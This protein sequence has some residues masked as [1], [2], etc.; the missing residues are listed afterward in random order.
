[1]ENNKLHVELPKISTSKAPAMTL[2]YDA[3][4]QLLWAQRD[5]HWP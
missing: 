3:K 2:I 1:M 5:V 4:G